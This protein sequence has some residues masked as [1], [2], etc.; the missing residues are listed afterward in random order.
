MTTT[1]LHR[2]VF[3][4]CVC[5]LSFIYLFLFLDNQNFQQVKNPIAVWY[6]HVICLS[7]KTFDIVTKEVI[8]SYM[9]L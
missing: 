9:N 6:Y 5:V 7:H 1:S 3:V 8:V 2:T 4:V